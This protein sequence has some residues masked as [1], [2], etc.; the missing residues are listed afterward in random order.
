MAVPWISGLL[1]QHSWH[2]VHLLPNPFSLI[3]F[4]W[5]QCQ[6]SSSWRSHSRI[7]SLTKCRL[8]AF[9]PQTRLRYSL[10]SSLINH[11]LLVLV[12]GLPVR[13][14]GENMGKRPVGRDQ[15]VGNFIVSQERVGVSETGDP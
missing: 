3:T 6:Y 2:S 5:R 1:D 4:T 11:T 8:G 15:H 9:S 12:D 14:I 10:A 13:A 7:R